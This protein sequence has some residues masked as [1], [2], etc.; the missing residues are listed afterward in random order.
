MTLA[1]RIFLANIF[2]T[3]KILEKSYLIYWITNTTPPL[4]DNKYLAEIDLIWC[5]SR[6]YFDR[7]TIF[8][9]SIEVG[10][11]LKENI[12]EHCVIPHTHI[13]TITFENFNMV[14]IKYNSSY[15]VIMSWK[16][17]AHSVAHDIVIDHNT[18]QSTI[19]PHP[20]QKLLMCIGV[21]RPP[22]RDFFGIKA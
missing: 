22:G 18:L 12:I 11:N 2:E 21:S 5:F 1:F 17:L 19:S 3:W 15:V 9:V 10:R 14:A 13:C 7:K 6:I 8:R 16:I 20:S 4:Y